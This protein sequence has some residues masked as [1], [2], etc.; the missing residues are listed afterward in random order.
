MQENL[1]GEISDCPI[2]PNIRLFFV[3]ERAKCSIFYK[4]LFFSLNA[5]WQ[6]FFLQNIS[7]K[8]KKRGK[9]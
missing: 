5:L 7:F 1:Q 4:L 8:L 6:G 3:M 9:A 2:F